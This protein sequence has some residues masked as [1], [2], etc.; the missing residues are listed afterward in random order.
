[1][2]RI[3]GHVLNFALAKLTGVVSFPSFHTTMALAYVW[4]FRRTGAVG[5][6]VGVSIC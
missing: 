6:M 5:W 2:E 4:G 3:R 1:M